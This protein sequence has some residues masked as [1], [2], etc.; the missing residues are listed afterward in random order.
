MATFWTMTPAAKDARP[1]VIPPS[2]FRNQRIARATP[3]P[4]SLRSARVVPDFRVEIA[5][6]KLKATMAKLGMEEGVPIESPMVS[7]AIEWFFHIPNA[8]NSPPSMN[9]MNANICARF[10][11]VRNPKTD[12]PVIGIDFIAYP[13]PMPQRINITNIIFN[14]IGICFHPVFCVFIKLLTK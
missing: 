12:N 2:V 11:S 9:M 4:V 10:P 14:F 8:N 6:D 13:V 1:E 3:G 7:R 5:G